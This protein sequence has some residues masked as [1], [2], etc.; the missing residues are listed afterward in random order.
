MATIP[1]DFETLTMTE[2]VRLQ[3]QL[4]EVLQRRFERHLA[5]AFTDV[6]GSTSYFERFGDEAGRRM[7]QH[8]F[9]LL[10]SVLAESGGRI[11]DTAGDGAFTCFPTV[12]QAAEALSQLQRR[13]TTDNVN[14]GR[15]H[16]MALRVGLHWGRVLTDGE[17]VTGDAVNVCSRVT[18]TAAPGEIRITHAAYVEL[19][20]EDRNRCCA[21]VPALQL[22]GVSGP[23]D[24][25]VLEWLDRAVFPGAL[26]IEET[27]EVIT[28]PNQDTVSFGRLRDK[29]GVLANDVVLTHPD[30]QL[31][32]QVS[33]WHFEL[34]RHADGYKLRQISDGIT[35]VDGQL[36]RRTGEVPVGPGSV[37]RVSRIL[38][39][40]FLDRDP[41][42]I[43][44]KT[45]APTDVFPPLDL[46]GTK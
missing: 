34:R 2:I 42:T 35:E 23:V 13:V 6:V 8:H 26:Q 28:L 14:R 3:N 12:P 45:I 31:A 24:A 37:V 27:G 1:G 10:S 44:E 4:S 5:L 46:S 40:R 38:T 18:G 39:V 15:E 30:K 41:K 36:V 9:D 22:R 21:I 11:V 7:Q 17:L 20:S 32:L 25:M 33:R 43:I 16:Q 29:D 19:G